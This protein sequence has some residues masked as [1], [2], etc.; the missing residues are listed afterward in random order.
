MIA[1]PPLLFYLLSFHPAIVV[2]ILFSFSFFCLVIY[3]D[4]Y[5]FPNPGMLCSCLSLYTPPLV[6]P[7]D[8]TRP[9]PLS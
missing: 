5:P 9:I 8:P 4:T 2:V 1:R 3:T 7:S 6:P